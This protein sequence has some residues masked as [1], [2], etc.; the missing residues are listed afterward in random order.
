[1]KYTFDNFREL[2]INSNLG[3]VEKN[4]VFDFDGTLIKGDIEEAFLCYLLSKN[5]NLE[6]S[7]DEYNHLLE[8][9]EYK[10]AYIDMKQ[11]FS[12]LSIPQLKIEINNFLNEN[13]DLIK[14]KQNDKDYNYKYPIVNYSLYQIVK[15]LEENNFGIFVIS[16]SLEMLVQEAG[17]AWF[18][19]NKENIA[20]MRLKPI[21]DNTLSNEIID[22]VTIGAGK[23]EA[24]KQYFNIERPFLV[25]GDSISDL[26][27]LNSVQD[28][29]IKIIVGKNQKL[30]EKTELIKISDHKKEFV[31]D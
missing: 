1:M 22:I 26:E 15:F 29:G 11:S 30:L 4:A 13:I 8:L 2:I 18:G 12:K 7:W 3:N 25:A 20:G 17:F 23:V 19:I 24:L 28:N 10:K 31:L 16:A 5:Y 9:G 27:L 21:D 6:Y 14:F